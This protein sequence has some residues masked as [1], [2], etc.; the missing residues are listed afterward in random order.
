MILLDGDNMKFDLGETW[1]EQEERLQRWH[2]WFAWHPVRVA[3][4]DYRWLEYVQRKGT[5]R[6][7]DDE[8]GSYGTI[9]EYREQN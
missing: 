5:W 3:S 7:W 2:R 4:H 1:K 9:W 8:F 6:Y